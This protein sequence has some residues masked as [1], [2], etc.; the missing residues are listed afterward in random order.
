[1]LFRSSVVLVGEVDDG[2]DH[3][4]HLLLL[5]L[6]NEAEVDHHQPC[7]ALVVRPQQVARVRVGVEEAR[8]QELHACGVKLR[9]E[10][11][12]FNAVWKQAL[13]KQWMARK[14]DMLKS[15]QEQEQKLEQ[16]NTRL[17]FYFVPLDR[18]NSEGVHNVQHQQWQPI[19]SI[20]LTQWVEYK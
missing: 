16:V 18:S 1:M 2:G 6:G 9:T 10:C 7:L 19:L 11:E 5:D 13:H 8:L 4:V 20:P 12:T 3:R 14:L 15:F 17:H